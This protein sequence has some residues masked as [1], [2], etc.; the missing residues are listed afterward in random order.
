MRK[1][2]NLFSIVHLLSCLLLLALGMGTILLGIIPA[3]REQLA[4]FLSEM[5]RITTYIGLAITIAALVFTAFLLKMY[6]AS[7]VTFSMGGQKLSLSD[8]FLEEQMRLWF[9]EY[10]PP[11]FAFDGI[12]SQNG[13]KLEVFA[14][15]E[16]GDASKEAVLDE[17]DDQLLSH[18]E[19]KL[20]G[21]L[22]EFW[23][24]NKRFTLTLSEG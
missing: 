11:Y 21:L 13:K 2:D 3:F 24:Y 7:Y 1:S 23:G 20:Q 5:P 22:R 18:F 14:H 15:I 19:A 6:S 8:P 17:I 9:K 4:L 12:S 16:I 10:A